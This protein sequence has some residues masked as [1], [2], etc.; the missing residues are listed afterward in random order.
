MNQTRQLTEA[1]KATR[2]ESLMAGGR[3]EAWSFVAQINWNLAKIEEKLA[4]NE[5]HRADPDYANGS[6]KSGASPRLFIDGYIAALQEAIRIIKAQQ[7]EPIPI[8]G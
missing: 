3:Q 2:R 7:H 6:M 5:A 8:I 1:Q 4:E